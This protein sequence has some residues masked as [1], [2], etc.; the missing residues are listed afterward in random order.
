M[1]SSHLTLSASAAC[2]ALWFCGL[3]GRE[4]PHLAPNAARCFTVPEA[5]LECAELCGASSTPPD[6]LRGAAEIYEHTV[7]V[8]AAGQVQP[9]PRPVI[10][11]PSVCIACP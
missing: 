7:F 6:G 2:Q 10:T 3:H 5:F 9:V 1:Y 4:V 11:L 8:P